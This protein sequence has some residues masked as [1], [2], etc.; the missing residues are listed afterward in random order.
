M[1][2]WRNPLLAMNQ[3]QHQEILRRERHLLFLSYRFKE[4]DERRVP[5][6][7]S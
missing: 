3:I 7:A 4:A 2:L 6:L 1:Q 5:N